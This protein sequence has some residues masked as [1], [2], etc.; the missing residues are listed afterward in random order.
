MTVV[1]KDST[2]RRSAS[3]MTRAMAR[4]SGLCD[5]G[6]TGLARTGKKRKD[7]DPQ[8]VGDLLDDTARR[9][10]LA[11]ADLRQVRLTYAGAARKL[12][13][14]ETCCTHEVGKCRLVDLERL[15]GAA[16]YRHA[17]TVVPKKCYV[18]LLAENPNT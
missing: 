12:G 1:G 18:K 10:A 4:R 8:R 17:D 3:R 6:S 16:R 9:A 15:C 11:G 13:T 7:A 14:V 5:I 2:R